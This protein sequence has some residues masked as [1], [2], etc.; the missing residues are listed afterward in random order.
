MISDGIIGIF[1]PWVGGILRTLNS[2]VPAVPGWME[3]VFN[4]IGSLWAVMGQMNAWV[5][6][7]FGVGVASA[8]LGAW[9][10]SMAIQITRTVI[11][12]LTFGG[13]AT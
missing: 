3:T 5:P 8:V 1:G 12:H 11:S 4:G 2:M 10:V 13:G 6:V 7:N 9:V